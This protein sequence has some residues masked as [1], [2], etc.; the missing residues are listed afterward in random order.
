M[1]KQNPKSPVPVQGPQQHS[2][3]AVPAANIQRSKFDLSCQHRTLFDA[4][5]LIP[6]FADEILPG[7]TWSI[8]TA[9][10]VRFATLQV[11][12]MDDIYIDLHWWFV[13]N[14]LIWEHWQQFMGEQLPNPGSST[15]YTVPQLGNATNS[16]H[17]PTMYP[18]N[19][20]F[21][22]LGYKAGNAT[23]S[24]TAFPLVDALECRAYNLIYN[25]WYRDQNL[26]DSVPQNI[27]DGPDSHDDYVVLSRL[28]RHDY[29]TGCLPFAQKGDA[30]TIPFADSDAP[31]FLAPFPNN[32]NL[33][34]DHADGS[35][36]GGLPN[37]GTDN[38][39]GQVGQLFDVTGG[40]R[41]LVIDPNGSWF[42]DLSSATLITINSFRQGVA[43]QQLLERDARGGTRYT[44]ILHSHFG[45]I[46]PDARLQRP[47]FLGQQSGTVGIYSVPQSTPGTDTSQGY[48]AAFG[49]STP[50]PGHVAHSFVEHGIIMG[51]LSTRARYTYTQ[52]M[53]RGLFR[54]TRYDYYWPTF[55]MLGEQAVL[56]QEIFVSGVAAT[57]TA[58]FGYQER[59]AEYR[60]RPSIATSY[61]RTDVTDALIQWELAQN[62]ASLP[63]L[64]EDFITEAPPVDQVIA[65]TEADGPAFKADISFTIHATRALPIYSVP[66]LL[67]L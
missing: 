64:A 62:F 19:S 52:G 38:R 60:Y 67:R 33:V 59:W 43:V 55:A 6:V 15:A 24:Y 18:I 44:E 66:G 29:F 54:Q 30:V 28:K 49:L 41:D 8:K 65:V 4:G 57:D 40:V 10:L 53:R 7:D 16:S 2:F 61:F 45:V 42:A 48:L 1:S 56:N 39:T 13:P 37:I 50:T 63:T 31:V 17:H 58:V 12:I 27:D 34:Y 51:I 36:Q 20:L 22:Y 14:R 23:P 11:P 9:M 32:A 35:L 5:L 25:E 21:D 26:V 3:S 46:S 47:E